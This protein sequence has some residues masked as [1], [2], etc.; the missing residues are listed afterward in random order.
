MPSLPRLLSTRFA[1][2]VSTLLL[3]AASAAPAA[4]LQVSVGGGIG[5]SYGPKLNA[6]GSRLAY[7][8]ATNPTGG[9]ADGSWEVFVYDRASGQTRQISD[10]PGGQFAGGNQTPGISGDGSRVAFQHFIID[11]GYGYF[12]TRV[13]D[14]NTNA[15]T[16]LT[17]PAFAETSAISRDGKTVA[18]SLGN[19]GVRLYDVATQAFTSLPLVNPATFT[20]SGD[21]KRLVYDT[22]SQGVYLYD[23]TTGATTVIS[24]AG[25]GGG[26]NQ[27]PMISADGNSVVFTSTFDPLGRN[28]DHSSEVFRYDVPTKTLVQVTQSQ[29]DSREASLS[30]DGTRILFSSNGD[31]A[32]RNADGNVEIFV[33]DLL[34]NSFLQMTDALNSYSGGGTLSEDGNTVAYFSNLDP[35]GGS[36]GSSYQIFLDALD[37]RAP[38]ALPEPA[39]AWLALLALGGAGAMRRR[40]RRG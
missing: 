38:A 9:N 7:Y 25:G 33:Y 21:G 19:V 35:R 5:Q 24:A 37:P 22:F 1:G 26:F 10:E 13:Y 28:A 34:A 32:G 12:Q 18:V 4:P 14:L 6:D 27:R 30:G 8:S 29:G 15:L 20:M 16:T 31:L 2:S 17:Q 39:S 11:S 36:P 3:L 40:Q 23:V